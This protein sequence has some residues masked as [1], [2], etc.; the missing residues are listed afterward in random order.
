MRLRTSHLVALIPLG[1]L[2]LRL[3]SGPTA[4]LSY[5]VISGYA[6]LGRTQA[7]QA[8]ALS[9]LFTMLSVGIAPVPVAGSIGRYAVIAAAA[10]SVL[11]RIKPG[12][13]SL[14]MS[15][16]VLSTLLL[17]IFLIFHSFY[18]SA[19]VD[20]SLLK[21][22]SWTVV[23][24]TLF[25]AWAGLNDE[26]RSVLEHELFG[27]LI[28]LMLVSLPFVFTG[29]GYLTNGTGFQGVLNQPQV[30]GQTV[31]LLG[32]WL[33]GRLLGTSQPGWREAGLL[34]LCLV[35]ILMSEARTAGFA[36]VLGVMAASLT[37]S[38][39]SGV[40]V[41]RLLP[42]LSS[43][44]LHGLALLAVAALVLG[45][46]VV[47]DRLET[48]FAK[49]SGTGDLLEAAD[50]SR[51]ELVDAMLENIER[52]P[53]TGIGFGIASNPS[54]MKVER[55]PLLGLPTGAAIEKG[56]LAVAVVEEI[57]VL[58]TL[59]VLV[60]ISMLVRRGAKSGVFTL[61]VLAIVLLMNFGEATL[62]SPGGMGL[63]PLILL[64]WAATGKPFNFRR[65]ANA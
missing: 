64:T 11:L 13:T 32:G 38:H 33:A 40:P 59:L 47:S 28:V 5:L 62:F 42:G 44:R 9:W 61:T 56:V 39:L 37:S 19:V 41:R 52:E 27:G 21:A 46:P 4:G 17:G 50:A 7:I 23:V 1:A 8:L 14:R 48:Y 54:M 58:G 34:A 12:R 29:I 60:W 22:L 43:P 26:A 57:G 49:R 63:L 53:L 16:L 18:F 3:A 15:P 45:A 36:L 2:A 51:G 35:L 24:A 10:L 31:A 65:R 6:L 30:F 25:A 20:V 55:D